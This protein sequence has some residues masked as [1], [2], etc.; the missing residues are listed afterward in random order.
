MLYAPTQVSS[1]DFDFA[2]HGQGPEAIQANPVSSVYQL[3]LDG[4]QSDIAR[5]MLERLAIECLALSS[6][7]Y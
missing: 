6:A 5:L 4:C 1:E 2:A 7:L 3:V